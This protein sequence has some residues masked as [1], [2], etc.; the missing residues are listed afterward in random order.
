VS[1]SGNRLERLF[2]IRDQQRKQKAAGQNIVRGDELPVE[3]NRQGYQRWYMHPDMLENSLNSLLVYVQEIPPGG[4][5]G[6][7]RSQGGH[8][9][10]VWEGRG[11]TLL[12]G[13]RHDWE[14]H[15]VLNFPVRTKGIVL[16]HVNAD[17]D[18]PARVLFCEPNIIEPLGMD[19]G[20][21]FEQLEDA[22]D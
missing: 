5:T 20:C 6:K 3:R 22:P 16:Q 21:G 10:V 8:V 9:G 19:R 13:V 14:Q 15:D 12:D 1:T 2:E 11:Y 18:N 7:Q 4:R 17:P